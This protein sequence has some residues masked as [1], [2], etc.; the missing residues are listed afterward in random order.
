MLKRNQKLAKTLSVVTLLGAF[1][2]PLIAVIVWLL[3]DQFAPYAAGYFPQAYDLTGLTTGERFVGFALLFIGAIIQAYGLLGLTTTFREAANGN[4]LS[5][6]AINGF[7]RFAWITLIM[8]VIAIIQRTGLIAIL[9]LSDPAY[10][11]R[12]DIQFGSNEL[13]GLFIGLVLVFVAHVFAEG[14]RAKDENETFL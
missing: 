9:S 2:L 10:Q 13:K 5:E 1:A 4:P 14:K 3:W 12:L 11:G 6:R 7:R 8:V